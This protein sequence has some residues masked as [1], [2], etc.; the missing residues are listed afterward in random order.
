MSNTTV[1]TIDPTIY[2][3]ARTQA[4]ARAAAQWSR[5]MTD[6]NSVNLW[7]AYNSAQNQTWIDP[8]FEKELGGN[9]N[10]PSTGSGDPAYELTQNAYMIYAWML[11]HGYCREAIISLLTVNQHET[12]MTAGSWEDFV[13]PYAASNDP[14]SLIGYDAER[15]GQSPYNYTWY[16]HGTIVPSWTDTFYDESNHQT[17]SL[18]APAG[19]WDAVKKHYIDTYMG[20]DNFEHPYIP[21]RFNRTIVNPNQLYAYDYIG[22]GIVQ[23]TAWSDTLVRHA[24]MCYPGYGG[25]HW[26]WNYTFQLMILEWERAQAMATPSE[27][28]QGT[29]YGEWINTA[30]TNASFIHNGVQYNYPTECTWDQWA[31]GDPVTWVQTKC[32]DIGVTDQQLIEYYTRQLMIDVFARCYLHASAYHT[33]W[34]DMTTQ[35]AYFAGAVDYWNNNGGGDIHDVPRARDL[36]AT[37]LDQFHISNSEL[38]SCILTNNKRE[39]RRRAVTIYI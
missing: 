13:S 28:Q 20:D 15:T 35:S 11:Y 26:Q 2:E 38:I 32:A 10:G 33:S 18:T 31:S 36:P 27:D 30:A 1:W 34:S 23:W 29:Y 21:L 25:K 7:T 5:W 8:W 3:Y 14:S 17:Y 37:E 16:L 24:E 19:S 9:F 12:N 39:V 22:Y 4:K 6:P